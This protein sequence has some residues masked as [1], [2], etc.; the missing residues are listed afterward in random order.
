VRAARSIYNPRFAV[1][2]VRRNVAS[3][4]YGRLFARHL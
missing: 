3:A 4:F 2:L 1:F